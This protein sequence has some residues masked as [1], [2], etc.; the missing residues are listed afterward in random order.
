VK[1]IVLAGGLGTR[2]A[3]ITS[4]LPKPMAPIGGRPFLEYLLDYL[5]DQG[6]EETVL[7][8][9]YKWEIIHDHFGDGYRGMPL[10]YSVE[11]SPLGTGGAIKQ[12]LDVATGDEA[13]VLNGDT[14][15]L[16]DLRE[17]MDVH[18]KCG[19]LLTIALKQI[20]NTE[21]YGRIAVSPQG[22]VAGFLEK[23]VKGAGTING[24]I[25]IIKR[26]LFTQ[27]DMPPR[28]SF[29][30]DLIEPNLEK[31]S[32]AAYCSD[33]Y[34]IDMGIPEDYE[35]ACREISSEFSSKGSHA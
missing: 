30:M 4:Q 10:S 2:L 27:Y 35:R 9:S 15:F 32:P 26:D 12:A 34:F 24:G 7:A 8:V 21:R 25:Y 3:G 29:E 18:R 23:G 16:L 6:V 5:V 11:E 31:I 20:E 19:A 28:F 1:S 13:V 33:A 22:R 14:L 17:M